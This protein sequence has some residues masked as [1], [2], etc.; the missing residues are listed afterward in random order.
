ILDFGIAKVVSEGGQPA[1]KT[2]VL[3]TP[4]YMSPEQIRGDGAI[5][6]RADL[7]SLAHIAFA[8]L[9]GTP[10]WDE[11][12]QAHPIYVLM[13]KMIAGGRESATGRAKRH[14]TTLPP[15]FDAW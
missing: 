2:K 12:A 9:T 8:L 10:Y 14:D 6:P 11:E 4:L 7:Y 3:G 15:A 5:G 1:A 13:T